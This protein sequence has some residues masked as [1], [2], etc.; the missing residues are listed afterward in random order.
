MTRSRTKTAVA[1]S[2]MT[3][4]SPATR[5]AACRANKPELALGNFDTAGLLTETVLLGNVAIL[6][7]KKIEWDGP[8]LKVANA[9]EAQKF[10]HREYRKGWTL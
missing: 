3:T 2:H 9:P 6:A 5:I 10:L 8:N 7:G 1:T 4:R